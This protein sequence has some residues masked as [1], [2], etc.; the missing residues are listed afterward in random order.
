VDMAHKLWKRYSSIWQISWSGNSRFGDESDSSAVVSIHCCI[1]IAVVRLLNT[2]RK[3]SVC[4]N[5]MIGSELPRHHCMIIECVMR[6]RA[7]KLLSWRL[8]LMEFTSGV[9]GV[10]GYSI[11]L[12]SFRLGCRWP[13][14]LLQ[15]T[16]WKLQKK[17]CFLPD[18]LKLL[19]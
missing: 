7:R 3:S 14:N 2:T 1:T 13:A 19:R 17:L 12:L 15:A 11:V 5:A 16:W 8:F 9:R 18:D 10:I 4:N 6:T